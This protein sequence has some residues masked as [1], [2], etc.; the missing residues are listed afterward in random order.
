MRDG[1]ETR[2][3]LTVRQEQRVENVQKET[4]RDNR[5]ETREM[6]RVLSWNL[7]H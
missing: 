6:S 1:Q 2:R 4:D 7:S 3:I 5:D